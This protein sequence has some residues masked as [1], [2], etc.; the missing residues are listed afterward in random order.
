MAPVGPWYTVIAVAGDVRG[1]ALEQPP[2]EI[3]Y[4]PLVVTLGGGMGS[5]SPETLWTPREF[6]IVARTDREPA[7]V[8]GRV[9]G[10]VRA[11][12]PEVPAYGARVMAEVV[13]QA[14][15]R[16]R[17]TLLLLGIASAAALALGSVGVYGVVSYGVSLRT[18]EIA[19]R[20]ALGARPAD[21]R[22]MISRQAGVLAALGVGV[23]LAAAAAMT[24]VLSALLF[25]VS[26]VDALTM[27]G[28]AGVLACVA[29]IASWVPARRAAALDPAQALRAD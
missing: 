1:T 21:V 12:D 10:A 18:R 3:I 6:A 19:V 9:E 24:R 2:D 23:G 26:P 15:A 7:L 8:A 25:G 20:L 14:A 11:L 13:A 28:A 29:A 27:I 17:L 16:T 5:A 22:R 4:L